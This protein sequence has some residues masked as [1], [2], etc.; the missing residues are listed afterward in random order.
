M[1]TAKHKKKKRNVLYILSGGILKEDFV[2]KHTRMIILIVILLV[3]FIG[4]RYT[5]LIKLR[6]ID[7]LQ[8]ELQDVKIESIDISGQLTGRNRRS[9]IEQLVKA[10]GLEIESAK[11]PPYILHK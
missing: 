7:R 9:Q 11:T 5:C 4:N 2:V 10:Q 6:E 1:K 3:F 8:R